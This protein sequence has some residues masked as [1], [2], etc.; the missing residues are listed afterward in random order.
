MRKLVRKTEKLEKIIEKPLTEKKRILYKKRRCEALN[1]DGSRCKHKA[2]GK[3]NV[4]V[5]H[6][7][8]VLVP[9]SVQESL[10]PSLVQK[11]NPIVHP[12][13]YIQLSQAGNS[14]SEIAANFQISLTTLKLWSTKYKEFSV[15]YE[16]GQAMHEAWWIREGKNNL[17]NRFYQTALYKFLTGNKLGWSEKIESKNMNQNTFGVLLVPGAMSID[18]WEDN[19]SKEDEVID[20]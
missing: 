7:G 10:P 16:V 9:E 4:C 12:M 6:G 3:G 14:D 17:D 19:N 1:A 11:Y 8:N 13:L 2:I 5:Q 15:A 20:V 18:E